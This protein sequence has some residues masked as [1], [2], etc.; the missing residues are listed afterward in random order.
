MPLPSNAVRTVLAATPSVSAIGASDWPASYRDAA[1]S[2]LS[3]VRPILR[4]AL[5]LLRMFETVPV[6]MP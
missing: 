3:A 6:P 1:S 5:C 4:L 2:T